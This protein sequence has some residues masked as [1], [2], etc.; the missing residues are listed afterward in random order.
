MNFAT[1]AA[2]GLKVEIQDTKGKA[3][4]GFSLSDCEEH[5]GDTLERCVVW[6]NG[7][8]VS[9]LA[10]KSVRLRFALKDADLYSIKFE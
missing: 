8:D 7:T 10:G 5:F 3:L 2:G 4:P 1:S 9:S 6:K